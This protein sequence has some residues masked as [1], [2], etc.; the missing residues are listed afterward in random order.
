M[1]SAPLPVTLALMT[2]LLL[3]D[4]DVRARLDPATAVR[5]VRDALLA[6]HAGDLDAPPRARAPLGESDLVF[7]AGRLRGRPGLHGFRAY[8][9]AG[10]A[11]QLVAVWDSAT[12]ALRAV[13]HG[14]ELGVRRTGAIGAVAVDACA[15]PGPVRVGLIGAGAQAWAQLWALRAVRPVAEVVVATRR[16]AAARDFARRAERAWGLPVRAVDGAETA[17]RGRDVVLVATSSPV[18]VLRAEWLEPGT[19][20][21]TLGPKTTARHEV[22]VELAD[23]AAVTVTD[24]PA[25]LGAYPEPHVFHGRPI[26]SLGAVLAGEERVRQRAEDVTVFCSVGLA[27]T[28]VAVAGTLSG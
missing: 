9:A 18:P 10:A 19:H 2:P 12:G 17:V 11:E 21:T 24:S 3:G 7:T 25:Q 16:P 28:E 8:D 1:R 5:A 6:H 15:R 13:V 4:E 26:A 23:R 20:L 27:G 14:Q 22:P